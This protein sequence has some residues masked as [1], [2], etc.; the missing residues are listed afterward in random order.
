MRAQ[1]A[2]GTWSDYVISN[3]ATSIELDTVLMG[4]D[5][6]P[7]F[8]LNS[9]TYPTGQAAFKN[10]ETGKFDVEVNEFTSILYDSPN[11]D[12]VIS[13][14]NNYLQLKDI[15]CTNPNSYNDSI[16]NIHIRAD[17]SNNGTY[18]NLFFNIE[19]ADV[20]PTVNVHHVESALRSSPSGAIY[21]ILATSN[22][23]L[24]SSPLIN[25][26]IPVSGTWVDANFSG[27]GKN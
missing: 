12:F 17:R 3:D 1:N 4:C 9:I 18:S 11:G 23:N 10:V 22:Q 2:F 26:D 25:V 24:A 6:K 19:V 16:N 8:N 13:D 7:S 15:T 27:A 21:N 5:L 20:A 14:T